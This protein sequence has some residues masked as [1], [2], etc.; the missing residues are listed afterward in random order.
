M[1]DPSKTK[2]NCIAGTA[3]RNRAQTEVAQTVFPFGCK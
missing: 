1:E 2:E 3:S